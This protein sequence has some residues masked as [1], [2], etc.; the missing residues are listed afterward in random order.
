M[1]YN[2]PSLALGYPTFGFLLV[3]VGVSGVPSTT[4]LFGYT[5]FNPLPSFIGNSRVFGGFVNLFSFKNWSIGLFFMSSGG[6]VGIGVSWG[7]T[8]ISTLPG[9]VGFSYG[10]VGSE[11]M[12]LFGSFNSA[13]GIFG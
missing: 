3:S 1:V 4:L 2:S 13:L 6:P 10:R 12:G 7:I 5:T 11:V 8:M 9:P